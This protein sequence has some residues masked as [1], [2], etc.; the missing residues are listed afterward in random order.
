MC[1]ASDRLR[2]AVRGP[3]ELRCLTMADCARNIAQGSGY[4]SLASGS[5]S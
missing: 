5:I 3:R 2:P 1:L 4:E